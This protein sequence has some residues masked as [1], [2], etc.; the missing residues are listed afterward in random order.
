MFHRSFMKH[1]DVAPHDFSL[2]LYLL[3]VANR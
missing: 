2:D 3:F 1:L